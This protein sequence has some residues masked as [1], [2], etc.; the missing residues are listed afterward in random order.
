M[1]W[2]IVQGNW[3]VFKG[4]VKAKWGKLTDDDIEVARG[5]REELIGRLHQ[6]Y[7]LGKDEAEKQV[8][9]ILAE[10]G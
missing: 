4:K 10:I 7:G 8:D 3:E 9:K 2:D 5:K 1:N 6:K